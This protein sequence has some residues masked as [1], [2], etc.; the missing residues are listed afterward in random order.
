MGALVILNF[1]CNILSPARDKKDKSE[2]RTS[3]LACI[4]D[5][6]NFLTSSGNS[7]K[8]AQGFNFMDLASRVG[9]PLGFKG[10]QSFG[11]HYP[12]TE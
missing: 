12:S 10:S 2:E 8:A 7:C 6:G 11:P 3:N 5:L 4:I 9:F 1:L